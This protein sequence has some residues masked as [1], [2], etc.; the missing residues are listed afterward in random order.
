MTCIVHEVKIPCLR[1]TLAKQRADEAERTEVL[2]KNIK[3][4]LIVAGLAVATSI[5]YC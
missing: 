3:M 4:G 2:W 5:A 1:C